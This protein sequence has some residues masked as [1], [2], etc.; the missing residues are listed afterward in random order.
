MAQMSKTP[1]LVFWTSERTAG[2]S[3]V[4]STARNVSG[5][6][7]LLY[8]YFGRRKCRICYWTPRSHGS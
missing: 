4:A 7:M 3:G 8:R 5:P 6:V 1:P 2:F